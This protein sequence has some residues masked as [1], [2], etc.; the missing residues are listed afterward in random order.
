MESERIQLHAQVR[1]RVQGVGFRMFVL[2][3]AEALGLTGFVRN[4]PDAS[5]QVVAQGPRPALETLLAALHA[6]PPAA[7]VGAVEAQWGPPAADAPRRFE[8]RG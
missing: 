3:R 7:R 1:G 8:V 2:D 5:V 6:G 4:A